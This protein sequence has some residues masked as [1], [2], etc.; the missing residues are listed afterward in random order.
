MGISIVL[1]DSFEIVLDKF[2]GRVL[3]LSVKDVYIFPKPFVNL[4]FVGFWC[5]SIILMVVQSVGL[6]L[7]VVLKFPGVI[8]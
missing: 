8:Y 7:G 4:L 2:K 3:Q 6:G 5:F 1:Q